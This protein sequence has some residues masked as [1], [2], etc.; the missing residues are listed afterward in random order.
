LAS[1]DEVYE[2]EVQEYFRQARRQEMEELLKGPY[3]L[4]ENLKLCLNFKASCKAWKWG[5]KRSKEGSRENTIR[6]STEQTY[7]LL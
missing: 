6:Q 2:R 3:K 5:L 1:L 4:K 7:H